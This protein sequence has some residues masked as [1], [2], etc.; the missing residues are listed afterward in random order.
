MNSLGIG[1]RIFAVAMGL[2]VGGAFCFWHGFVVWKLWTWHAVA[3]G[4]PA[5]SYSNATGLVLIVQ[6]VVPVHR[7]LHRIPEGEYD[8]DWAAIVMLLPLISLAVGWILA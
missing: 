4:L 3:A 1:A 6:L 2:V 8:H 7:R 5:L